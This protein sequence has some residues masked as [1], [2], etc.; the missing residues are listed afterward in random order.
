MILDAVTFEAT[1]EGDAQR[2]GTV[3]LIGRDLDGG[4]RCF[5]VVAPDAVWAA[6]GRELH[7]RGLRH[8]W[9]KPALPDG[10]A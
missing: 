1:E 3:V 9:S 4:R 5:V 2:A 7:R 10:G 6:V 8:D